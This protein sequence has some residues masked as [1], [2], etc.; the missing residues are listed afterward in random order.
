MVQSYVIHMERSTARRPLV[1]ELLQRLPDAQV[2]PAV[3]GRDLSDDDRA[4]VYRRDL[5]QPR[6]PF[7]LSVGEIGC[8]LSHRSA[9][10]RIA[11]G[12]AVAGVVAEDDVIPQ[13]GFDEALQLALSEARPDRLIRMPMSNR[14]MAA[15]QI[16]VAGAYTLVRPQVVGLTAALQII[17]RDAARR[18]VDLTEA[19][20]RPIDTFQQMTWLTG[21]ETLSVLPSVAET[22]KAVSGGS[23]IQ[24][25]QSILSEVT[26]SW[27]RMR[28]RSKV[29]RLSGGDA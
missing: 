23:T 3:V 9:W 20:D 29:A 15:R 21:I 19:F 2:L 25:H 18:L 4:R 26:R 27:R 16:A 24:T 7:D 1:D 28:Y 12:D 6:Y 11:E 14:E 22:Q 8:F 10:M 13:D 17:G 5:H